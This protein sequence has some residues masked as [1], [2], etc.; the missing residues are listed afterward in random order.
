L[1]GELAV[2]GRTLLD[3][4]LFVAL[5]ARRIL[6]VE[7]AVIVATQSEQAREQKN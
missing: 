2:L 4:S 7:V 1:D 5:A 6:L 3:L